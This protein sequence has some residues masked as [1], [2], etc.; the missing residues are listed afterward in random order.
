MR[1]PQI[2]S[3]W[4]RVEEFSSRAIFIFVLLILGTLYWSY[5]HNQS[6]LEIALDGASYSTYLNYQAIDHQPF[7]QIGVDA[8]QGGFDAYYPLV[9]EYLLPSALLLPFD[10]LPDK[11][12]T[13][14]IYAVFVLLAIYALART[15][16]VERPTALLAGFFFDVF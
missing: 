4:V 13:Y 16:G 7:T 14:F 5:A 10:A 9:R 8:A 1:F 3:E 2:P 11:A 6:C 15:I 12:V